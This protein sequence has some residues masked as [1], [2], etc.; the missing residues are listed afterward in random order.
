MKRKIKFRAWELKDPWDDK[1]GQQMYY[2]VEGA[3]DTLGHMENSKGE[4]IQYGWSSFGEVLG[5]VEEGKLA[6]MQ[7]TG[8]KDKNGKEIYEG[9]IIEYEKQWWAKSDDINYKHREEVS[10]N[11]TDGS[12]AHFAAGDWSVD[13]ADV[14]IIGNVHENPELLK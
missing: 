7:F 4:E 12:Y 11:S 5:D 3:Y 2:G 14:E 13:S 10:W 1:K 9:D 6:L 8:L